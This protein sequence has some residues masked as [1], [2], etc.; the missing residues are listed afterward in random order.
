MHQ[1]TKSIADNRNVLHYSYYMQ[2]QAFNSDKF[3]KPPHA[4]SDPTEKGQ[5]SNLAGKAIADFLSKK[6]DNSLY[7]V[8]YEAAMRLQGHWLTGKRP[9]LIAYYPNSVF[10]LEAKGRHQNNPGNMAIHKLQAQAGPIN[11]NFSV[12]CVSFNL[13]NQ[14]TCNYHDPFN[15]NIQ[16]DNVSLAALT[17]NYYK[18]LLEFLNQKFFEYREFEFQGERFYE[19]E[20]FNRSFEKIFPDEFL[21]TPFR[22]F[23][24]IDFLD[25]DLFC[26]LK[27]ETMRKAE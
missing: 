3:S 16:Y 26:L 5:F 7:T 19:I 13:F 20:L 25:Q 4:L 10:A 17:R 15:D 18:G 14:V 2:R 6:I 1:T 12:A 24:I 27:L 23:E 11:V 22:H 21:F 8:N 9:D